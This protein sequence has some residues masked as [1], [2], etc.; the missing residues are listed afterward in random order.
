MK[1]LILSPV[2]IKYFGDSVDNIADPHT[3][4][5]LDTYLVVRFLEYIQKIAS[6]VFYADLYS[7]KA[8]A[9]PLKVQEKL[10][11]FNALC[12]FKGRNKLLA[13]QRVETLFAI[14]I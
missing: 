3:I 14:V 5:S 9:R 2:S 10:N 11:A 13:L 4:L 1:P 6:P 7:L 8:Y 12:L